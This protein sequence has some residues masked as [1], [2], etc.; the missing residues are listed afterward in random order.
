MLNTFNA[1]LF[2]DTILNNLL[3]IILYIYSFYFEKY[4]IGYYK[5]LAKYDKKSVSPYKN[6]TA[7]RCLQVVSNES[8]MLRNIDG[9][10]D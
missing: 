5:K 3:R 6:Y 7:R 1:C 8:L 2:S 10:A 9:F 4:E